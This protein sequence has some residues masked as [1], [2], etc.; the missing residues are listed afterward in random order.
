[1]AYGLGVVLA[2]LKHFED[3]E[4]DHVTGWAATRADRRAPSPSPRARARAPSD[5]AH[6]SPR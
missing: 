6:K 4:F 2:G 1:V 3:L 5:H